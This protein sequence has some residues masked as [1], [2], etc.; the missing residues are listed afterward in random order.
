MAAKNIVY[1]DLETQRSFGD[2]GGF[3]N[4]DKMGVSVAV[5]T[6][7]TLV[8]GEL[9]PKRIALNNPE[10]VASRVPQSR[11]IRFMKQGRRDS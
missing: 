9:L 5:I 2:V 10:A 3:S 1:F 7:L 8:F 4:K 11:R 6:Y